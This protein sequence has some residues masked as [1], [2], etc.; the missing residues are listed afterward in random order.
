M[1]P[2]IQAVLEASSTCGLAGGEHTYAP[3]ETEITMWRESVHTA[4]SFG[5]SVPHTE[6]IGVA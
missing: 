6:K 5:P 1:S 3:Q 4:S 2:A